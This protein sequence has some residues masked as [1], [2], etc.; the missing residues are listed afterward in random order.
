MPFFFPLL[1]RIKEIMDYRVSF[2]FVS[3][4]LIW[5]CIITSNLFIRNWTWWT[6]PKKSNLKVYPKTETNLCL[7]DV[8]F[9]NESFC[10]ALSSIRFPLQL[11][12]CL[13]H[14]H[15]IGNFVSGWRNRYCDFCYE[16]MDFLGIW[17]N[18]FMKKGSSMM[19]RTLRMLIVIFC[20]IMRRSTVMYFTIAFSEWYFIGHICN[21]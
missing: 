3:D 11:Y 15:D 20:K 1:Q 5:A 8:H 2:W 19:E 21:W 12:M 13:H 6:P 17:W 10:S 18:R 9:R 14:I 4:F 16:C 7:F